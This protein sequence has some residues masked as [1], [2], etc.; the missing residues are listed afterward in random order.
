MVDLTDYKTLLG[1]INP[2]YLTTP[3]DP[4]YAGIYTNWQDQILRTGIDKNY[5]FFLCWPEQI[6]LS[7][8]VHWV[9]K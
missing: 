8:I 9:I 7:F 5:N 2:S 1:E 3:N 6:K 4:R